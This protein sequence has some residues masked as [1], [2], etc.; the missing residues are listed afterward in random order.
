MLVNLGQKV[1]ERGKAGDRRRADRHRLRIPLRLRIWE[2]STPERRGESI[3]ISASGAFMEIDWPLQVGTFVDLRLELPEEIIGQP[4]TEWH[5]KGRVVRVSAYKS[6]NSLTR[7]G[8]C[9]DWIDASR[10]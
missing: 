8:V 2:S 7:V 4:T 1:T 9:F 6:T 10:S 5:C 3:D